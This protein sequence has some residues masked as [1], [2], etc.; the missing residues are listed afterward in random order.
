LVKVANR[1][2]ELDGLEYFGQF[3]TEEQM[4]NRMEA[5]RKIVDKPY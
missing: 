3:E 1:R 2:N 5:V 4:K